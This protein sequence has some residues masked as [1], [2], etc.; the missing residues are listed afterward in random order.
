[1]TRPD[2]GF[3][4]EKLLPWLKAKRDAYKEEG[5]EP[6]IDLLINDLEKRL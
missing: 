2:N 4:P 6:T 3:L 5:K 1:M